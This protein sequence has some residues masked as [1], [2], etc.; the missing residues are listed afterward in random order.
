MKAEQILTPQQLA[1]L[2]AAEKKNNVANKKI[3]K[4]RR[5][6]RTKPPALIPVLILPENF[7]GGDLKRYYKIVKGRK[8]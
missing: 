4:P 8:K 3:G 7:T 6:R 1:K 5:R 2:A